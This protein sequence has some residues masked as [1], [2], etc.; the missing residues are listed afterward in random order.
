MLLAGSKPDKIA[1]LYNA[2]DNLE[3]LQEIKPDFD[4]KS[5]KV[6]NYCFMPIGHGIA[7]ASENQVV[8]N[9][10]KS[11][12]RDRDNIIPQKINSLGENMTFFKI[13]SSNTSS[14]IQHNNNM[15]IVD[16]LVEPDNTKRHVLFVKRLEIKIKFSFSFEDTVLTNTLTSQ[17]QFSNS[18]TN[19]NANSYL[20]HIELTKKKYGKNITFEDKLGED[21]TFNIRLSYDLLVVKLKV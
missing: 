6:I 7:S 13:K 14:N 15:F 19:K 18:F 2:R 4:D 5:K 20:K 12:Y 11:G 8:I 21:K 16:T 9:N 17:K 3:E 1:K 10:Y